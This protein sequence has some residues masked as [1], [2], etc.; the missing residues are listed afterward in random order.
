MKVR[1]P[2]CKTDLEQ[3]D[4]NFYKNDKGVFY[5]SCKDCCIKRTKAYL[6]TH[7]RKAKWKPPKRME[8]VKRH[9]QKGFI[10]YMELNP[11]YFQ[12]TFGLEPTRLNILDACKSLI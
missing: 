4:E 1:C 5:T 2:T 9:T 12:D 10:N 8:F 11:F 3:I 6:A 7:K